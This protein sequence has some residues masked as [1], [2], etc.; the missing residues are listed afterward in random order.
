MT[1]AFFYTLFIAVS[2]FISSQSK[3][4]AKDCYDPG[5]G[6]FAR[7]VVLALTDTV[8]AVKK[9]TETTSTE[10]TSKTEETQAAIIKEVPKSRHQVKPGIVKPGI[11]VNPIPIIKPK[12]IKRPIG[13]RL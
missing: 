12:I 13:I 11:Q 3:A 4:E 7:I 9:S 10:T 1:K 6:Y 8:P 5:R 2:V